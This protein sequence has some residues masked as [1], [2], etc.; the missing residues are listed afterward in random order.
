MLRSAPCG[1]TLCGAAGEE[2][3]AVA[4]YRKGKCGMVAK[5]GRQLAEMA[6][7]SVE[8]VDQSRAESREKRVTQMLILSM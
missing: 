7:L 2:R 6:I 1:C 8:V 5:R 3:R 4:R